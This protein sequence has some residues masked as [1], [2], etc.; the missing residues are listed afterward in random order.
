MVGWYCSRIL[1][2]E[3][4]ALNVVWYKKNWT[5]TSLR[6]FLKVASHSFR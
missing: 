5:V 2:H 4:M 3:Q 6:G 1:H